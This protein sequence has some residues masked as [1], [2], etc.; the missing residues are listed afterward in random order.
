[1]L[2][3]LH[4]AADSRNSM[5]YHDVSIYQDF[6]SI[7]LDFSEN[8]RKIMQIIANSVKIQKI[9]VWG[10]Y[11]SKPVYTEQNV[12]VFSQKMLNTRLLGQHATSILCNATN[13]SG[14][15]FLLPLNTVCAQV[16]SL[17]SRSNTLASYNLNCRTFPLKRR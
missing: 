5:K 15:F 6:N 8:S 10:R 17:L 3:Q 16:G 1:M 9:S 4:T 7:S 11:R 12:G 14:S 2:F 13:P